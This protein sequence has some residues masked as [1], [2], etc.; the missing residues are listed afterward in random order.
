MSTDSEIV[1]LRKHE[2]RKV[3]ESEPDS[4]SKIAAAIEIQRLWRGHCVRKK[5]KLKH[6]LVEPSQLSVI[7]AY[8]GE[9]NTNYSRIKRCYQ[10]HLQECCTSNALLPQPTFQDYC[11]KRIQDWWSSRKGKRR[12]SRPVPQQHP[13]SQKTVYTDHSTAATVIQK[14][15][16]RY[17]DI[18]VYRFYRDLISFQGLGDP[19][20]ML[21]CINP[22]EAKL[23][24]SGSGV[25]VKFRLGGEQ[26]PPSVYY[27]I[28]T[29]QNIVDLGA[30]SPRDYTAMSWKQPLPRDVHN[31]GTTIS[32][33]TDGWYCRW[34]NNGWR[35]VSDRLLL[36]QPDT[37][38]ITMASAEKKKQFHFSKLRRKED[39]VKARKRKK[40]AWMKQLYQN[41]MMRVRE[42][43]NAE[44]TEAIHKA[45]DQAIT[46]SEQKGADCIRDEDIDALLSWTD[47]L[48]FD[49]YISEWSAMGTTNTSDSYQS[50]FAA[51]EDPYELRLME[52]SR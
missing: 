23:L 25:R 52:N 32:Q 34:E 38:N 50:I 18:Q 41:G 13:R 17:N 22:K 39:I 10:E 9:G 51:T 44:T 29:Y 24:D 33:S 27:K 1:R 5:K 11:A 2:R 26:F 43:L 7:S 14:C 42:G 6:V 35:L 40:I 20:M 47:G 16:R 36:F 19:S 12:Q 49:H 37:D 8:S 48:N 28:F 30:Y 4:S 45:T 46:L 21:R 31:K 3:M 15:W